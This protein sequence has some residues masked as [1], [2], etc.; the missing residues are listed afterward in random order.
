MGYWEASKAPHGD[1]DPAEAGGISDGLKTACMC[2]WRWG[3][4]EQKPDLHSTAVLAARQQKYRGWVK[5]YYRELVLV[6]G[7]WS[8][9]F[10]LWGSSARQWSTS[11]AIVLP[12]VESLLLFSAHASL[13][14]IALLQLESRFTRRCSWIPG[15]VVV[16][17]LSVTFLAWELDP[18]NQRG[19]FTCWFVHPESF[20][21]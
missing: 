18:L 1:I 14:K 21:H 6:C 8:C 11:W 5:N 3:K 9:L 16:S 19:G 20:C 13:F 12:P 7:V 17:F 4:L 2:M 10:W 15:W